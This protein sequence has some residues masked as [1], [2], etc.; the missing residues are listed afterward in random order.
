MLLHCDTPG[1][2]L[3][4][5]FLQCLCNLV[6]FFVV[7]VVDDVDEAENRNVET[8]RVLLLYYIQGQVKP[9]TNT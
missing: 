7:V 6:Q 9:A 8:L 3:Y 1:L 5:S 2:P 4:L